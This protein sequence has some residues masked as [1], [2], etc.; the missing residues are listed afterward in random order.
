M[1]SI[2]FGY[3]M[4]LI[5]AATPSSGFLVAYDSDGIIKQKDSAGVITL[6]GGSGSSTG[7]SATS[8]LSQV[9]DVSND[10]ATYSILMGTATSI[11]MGSASSI[12]MGTSSFIMSENG[13][14]SLY[15]DYN[16]LTSSIYLTNG[17]NYLSID[18]S[19]LKLIGNTLSSN[20][21]INNGISYVK[22]SSKNELY[23]LNEISLRVWNSSDE[24]L[25]KSNIG[26]SVSSSNS[27][28]NAI[29]IGS[30]NS[31]FDANITNSVI[32]G[33]HGQYAISNDSVYIPDTYIQ[34]TKK[35]RGSL[36]DASLS[37][38]DTNNLI[39][40]NSNSL[41]AIISSSSSTTLTT[42]GIIIS[43]TTSTVTS[44]N[45]DASPVFI[46][47]KNSSIDSGVHNSVIIG[48]EN[49][50]S[51]LTNSV[52][53]GEFVNINNK[54]T[55]PNVDGAS[56][57]YL[58]T[59]GSGN[60]VWQSN[61][62]IETQN[63]ED[64][65]SIGNFTGYN[66]I[67]M[68]TGSSLY[69]V[70]GGGQINLDYSP[71]SV[72]ISTDNANLAKAYIQLDD[73]DIIIDTNQN[74]NIG[75]GTASVVVTNGEGLVYG[76][77]YSST[78]VTYSLIDKNYVDLGT[79]SIW[80]TINSI[81]NDFVSEIVA[82]NGLTG[83]GT[84]G[85][86]SV[87]LGGTLSQTTTIDTSTYDFTINSS[88]SEIELNRVSTTYPGV[89]NTFKLE[90]KYV[91]VRSK[92][93]LYSSHIEMTNEDNGQTFIDMKV[94]LGTYSNVS[95]VFNDYVYQ[96]VGSKDGSGS[97]S[98][99]FLHNLQQ[100][101]GDGSTNNYLIITDELSS[102]GFV[103]DRD[104]TG[105][106]TTHSLV[107]KG[108]VDNQVATSTSKYSTTVSFT[109][110]VIQTITHNLGTD[111]IIVQCY[112]SSGTMVIP[113]TVQINGANDVDITFSSN[114]SNVKTVIIG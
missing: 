57:S 98:S 67:E 71:N 105:N 24:I 108:Y 28:S 91:I 58:S 55:L 94:D 51:S 113:G 66:S 2:I 27:I 102:K 50:I 20:I 47:T 19:S 65:L 77:D 86:V 53:L 10:S 6:I 78:F 104:Y 7:I 23:S 33:G 112:D 59:D 84:S 100:T 103:Y 14:S 17:Y 21:E 41:L 64:V 85:S 38:T 34:D 81:N 52:V 12:L 75:A 4:S 74:L 92:S 48:G 69:S 45:I 73:E 16:S 49:L 5:D 101:I 70:R 29:F 43:D 114:L 13:L 80:S 68:G 42:N 39:L 109:A 62:S 18:N 106:F 96:A 30:Q 63:L 90:D 32:I 40:E 15:L 87:L 110:S 61:S 35:L 89:T 60:V 56:G 83:G 26:T 97:A 46:S 1:S 95:R 25:L 31:T 36:G 44:P 3:T 11:I 9:L 37:F 72:V 8:S 93:S 111:E 99:I 54:Y 76:F 22:L 88:S 79:S 82:G 107:T